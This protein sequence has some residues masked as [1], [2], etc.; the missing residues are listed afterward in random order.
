[1]AQWVLKFGFTRFGFAEMVCGFVIHAGVNTVSVFFSG[2]HVLKFI[3][4]SVANAKILEDSTRLS[5]RSFSGLGYLMQNS[6]NKELCP[7]SRS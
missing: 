4:G 2:A 7:K 5:G 1:M 3:C 6:E